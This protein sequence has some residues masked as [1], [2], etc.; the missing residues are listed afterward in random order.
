[1]SAELTGSVDVAKIEKEL[2][3]LWK[4]MAH[5]TTPTGENAVTRACVV[6][7][8]ICSPGETND[9]SVSQ[10]IG[11]ISIHHPA[12]T[13]I[14]LPGSEGSL[15][16]WVTAQCH[17]AAGQR[18]Q[19]CCEQIVVRAG[20]TEV[21]QLSSFVFPLLVPDLPVFLWWRG[22]LNQHSGLIREL[23]ETAH[24]AIFDSQVFS[25]PWHD[26]LVL[27]NLLR[28]HRADTAFSDLNWA[29]LSMWRAAIAECFD[30]PELLSWLP[31]IEKVVIETAPG[32]QPL[33]LTAWLASRLKWRYTGKSPDQLNFFSRQPTFVVMQPGRGD[34]GVEAVRFS[35]RSEASLS[36]EISKASDGTHLRRIITTGDKTMERA[37]LIPSQETSVLLSEQLDIPGRVPL[38]EEALDYISSLQS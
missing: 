15:S 20:G 30:I 28:T 33:L 22:A 9:S 11:D 35:F 1:M 24:R 26:F 27:G 4:Q 34:S 14:L 16:A 18:K 25:D 23:L 8:V 32:A 21:E 36:L 29:R 2:R 19:V 6:N 12:R 38:Y 37:L 10:V 5:P 13:M 7:L 3:E 17:F 31:R